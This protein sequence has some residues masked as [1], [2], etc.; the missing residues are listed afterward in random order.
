MV[1]N[2]AWYQGLEWGIELL[3]LGADE[4]GY[5]VLIW[6]CKGMLRRLS[7]REM[8][9][10]FQFGYT[11]RYWVSAAT[12][13]AG[14]LP[15]LQ[16]P[17]RPWFTWSPGLARATAMRRKKKARRGWRKK[18]RKPALAS[19]IP[20]WSISIDIGVGLFSLHTFTAKIKHIYHL[21]LPSCK[22][23]TLCSESYIR[24]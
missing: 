8:H 16:P 22:D 13:P 10:F 17:L 3:K 11:F 7:R 24:W 4:I 9:F 15:V 21:S 12:K 5:P 20:R 14:G 2:E 23:W 18:K 19:S 6:R 1:L